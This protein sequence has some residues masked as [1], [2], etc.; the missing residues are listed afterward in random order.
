M[1]IAHAVVAAEAGADVV[2]LIDDGPGAKAATG[3]IRRLQRLRADGSPTG[4]IS[5]ASTLI[6]LEKAA[7]TIHIPVTG[8]GDGRSLTFAGVDVQ[9]LGDYRVTIAYLSAGGRHCFIG[10]GYRWTQ[11]SF[12]ASGGLGSVA[13]V[14]VTVRLQTGRNTVE[15]GNTPGR[16]CPDLDRITVASAD[17][18]STA[19]S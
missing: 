19:T 15:A 4:S 1:V 3:E 14:T 11:V 5:L 13:T 10:A 2:V 16:W 12:P 18:P 9:R 7:A 17:H 6:V 8:V